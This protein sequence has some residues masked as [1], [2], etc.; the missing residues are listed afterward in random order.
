MIYE[1]DWF[2]EEPEDDEPGLIEEFSFRGRSFLDLPSLLRTIPECDFQDSDSIL[3]VTPRK[4]LTIMHPDDARSAWSDPA[5]CQPLW[6]WSDCPP[7]EGGY[8]SVRGSY[9][10]R[11]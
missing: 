5:P 11:G 4:N 8:G 6:A 2:D 9:E 1:R 3:V 7:Q 10:L